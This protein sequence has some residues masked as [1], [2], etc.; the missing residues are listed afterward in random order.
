MLPN[1]AAFAIVFYGILRRGAIAVPMNP[2]LKAREIEFFLTNTAAVALFATPMFADDGPRGRRRGGGPAVAGRRRRP[3][4]ADRRS[5]RAARAGGAGRRRHGG[6]PAHLGHHRQTQGRRTHPRRTGRQRRGDRPHPDPDRTRRRG[7]GGAAAVPRLRAHLRA[8]HLGAGRRDADAGAAVRPAHRARG[9]RPRQGHRL[10]GRADHVCRD[11]RCRRR[12]FDAEATASL[13]VCV[14]GG[15][16]LPVA[17]A[18]RLR[19]DLRRGDPGRLRAVGNLAGRLV[20]PPEPHPQA[21][22]D[23]HP[24]RGCADARGRR[25]RC[26]GRG[27]A[28]PARSRSRDR[29]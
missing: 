29:T 21:R 11:A 27:R 5:A 22:L 12:S 10:R 28:S 6:D 17:G 7:D 13:R 26:R 23:R 25:R 24:D 18:H 1:T 8:Q 19:A 2:L 20:Q 15:A 14:S 9:D 4:P 16:S 3:G